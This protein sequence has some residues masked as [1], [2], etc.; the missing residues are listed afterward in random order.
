MTLCVR[1]QWSCADHSCE[2]VV[3]V[4]AGGGAVLWW[5]DGGETGLGAAEGGV[6]LSTCAH[7]RGR[8]LS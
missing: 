7:G 2:R 8:C 3:V 5:G 1:L 6:G 4:E